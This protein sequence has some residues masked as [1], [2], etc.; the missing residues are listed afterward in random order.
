MLSRLLSGDSGFDQPFGV[1]ALPASPAPPRARARDAVE[2]DALAMSVHLPWNQILAEGALSYGMRQ[3][4][5]RLTTRMMNAVIHC[6]KQNRAF[7]ERYHALNATGLGER[8][9]LTGYA[10]VG[11]FLQTLGVRI[12]SPS[13][14]RLEGTNPFPWPVTTLY[15]G[16]RIERGIE[17][18]VVVFPNGQ[19]VT[20]SDPAPCIV[21]V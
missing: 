11:L 3:E 6:L 18:T 16:L 17:S 9:S 1:P 19:T 15:R 4:A 2:A 14:V 5:A 8:G 7:Y 21:A 12:L 10:P 20:V 13:R